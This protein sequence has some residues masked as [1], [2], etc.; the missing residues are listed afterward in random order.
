MATQQV[1]LINP[2]TVSNLDNN[3]T[4]LYQGQTDLHLPLRT[5]LE[6]IK[7]F[8]TGSLGLY[9]DMKN[10]ACTVGQVSPTGEFSYFYGSRSV[11]VNSTGGNNLT[12]SNVSKLYAGGNLIQSINAFGE[13]I[14]D[15]TNYPF[16]ENTYFP[17][18]SIGNIFS[19]AT[20]Q[21]LCDKGIIR[22]NDPI[23]RFF[24]TWKNMK[25]LTQRFFTNGTGCYA[26]TG[27][28]GS[29]A[30]FLSAGTG[31]DLDALTVTLTT[32]QTD[33]ITNFLSSGLVQLVDTSILPTATGAGGI[34]NINALAANP[35]GAQSR[36][37][38][39]MQPI[40]ILK[41]KKTYGTVAMAF[42]HQIGF[43]TYTNYNQLAINV[44]K[45]RGLVVQN[46]NNISTTPQATIDALYPSGYH[47]YNWMNDVLSA[48]VLTSQPGKVWEYNAGICIGIACCEKAYQ[49]FYGLAEP[50]PFWQIMRDLLFTPCGIT[51][52]IIIKESEIYAYG[53]STGAFKANV[54]A[55]Y[56]A[57]PAGPTVLGNVGGALYPI[58]YR[59]CALVHDIFLA[60]CQFVT[61]KG[62]A[63]VAYM[64]AN[65]GVAKNGTR[66]MSKSAVKAMCESNY[67][68][69]DVNMV[70]YD[71]SNI[72]ME[73]LRWSIVP[74]FAMT[75]AL[76]YGLGGALFRP[77]PGK[78][79]DA[80]GITVPEEWY[81][82]SGAGM[83]T[84]Y[85]KPSEGKYIVAAMRNIPLS[86]T[87]VATFGINAASSVVYFGGLNAPAAYDNYGINSFLSAYNY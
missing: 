80:I 19:S 61:M 45:D 9:T 39:E 48:G 81:M 16:D 79:L 75:E 53:S 71:E 63:K 58:A 40:Q 38:V 87:S 72:D 29:A 54:L 65:Y 43:G 28:L 59:N 25:V 50:K 36:Y 3:V 41:D 73:A 51:D 14:A 30:Q 27:T 57:A 26:Q 7:S 18:Y 67:L 84:F 11:L 35:T 55:M 1:Y 15:N 66:V 2:N 49:Q 4:A 77:R 34:V 8:M 13:A 86:N 68:D 31:T 6:H 62:L 42:S 10:I 5:D 17:S 20:F 24:P 83:G 47:T 64:L 52:E 78:V 56:G 74:S 23:I 22:S 82:W 44:L 21:I 33:T 85:V 12:G 60:G 32:G 76:S 69:S 37:Y 46:F 70:A